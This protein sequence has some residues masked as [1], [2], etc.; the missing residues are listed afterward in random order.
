M[1][2]YL[3]MHP[4][5]YHTLLIHTLITFTWYR[6]PSHHSSYT[7]ITRLETTHLSFQ[8]VW[9]YSLLAFQGVWYIHSCGNSTL[10]ISDGHN[11]SHTYIYIYIS[12]STDNNDII[13][14]LQTIN[15]ITTPYTDPSLSFAFIFMKDAHRNSFVSAPSAPCI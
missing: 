10:P 12:F 3:Y 6:T 1:V 11:N 8:G 9:I 5:K 2:D 15:D 4:L 7:Y 13:Y 14:V